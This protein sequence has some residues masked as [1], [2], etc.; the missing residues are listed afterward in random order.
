MATAEWIPEQPALSASSLF[1]TTIPGSSQNFI[2]CD[3]AQ[4]VRRYERP[5]RSNLIAGTNAV[6]WDRLDLDLMRIASLR[7]N[8]DDDGAD[9]IS[10]KA[11]TNTQLLLI[12]ARQYLS[13][14]H[15]EQGATPVLAPTVEGGI[16]LQWIRGRREMKCTVLND[17]VE[18]SRWSSPDKYESDGYWEVPVNRISEGLKEHFD[19]I[20]QL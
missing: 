9:P 8:W 11:V 14:S 19:W 10:Q 7:A 16:T 1:G 6:A 15:I 2:E 12:L 20:L 3:R 18:V 13:Y 4:T 17:L 5:V